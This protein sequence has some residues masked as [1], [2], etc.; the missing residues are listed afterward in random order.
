MDVY[1]A[2][3]PIF[4]RNKNIQGHELPFRHGLDN[5]FPNDMDGDTAT[6]NFVTR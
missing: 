4:D 5:F 3:Q 6:S 2:R 1:V